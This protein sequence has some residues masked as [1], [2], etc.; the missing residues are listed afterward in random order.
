MVS[1]FCP[2]LD[3]QGDQSKGK[4][5]AVSGTHHEP[6][7]CVARA[8][9]CPHEG[10][11]NPNHWDEPEYLSFNLTQLHLCPFTWPLS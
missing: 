5:D 4:D 8:G 1:L 3:S 10:P 11:G 9:V 2:C 7:G 6:P